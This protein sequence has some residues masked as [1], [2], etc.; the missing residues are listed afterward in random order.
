MRV[1]EEQFLVNWEQYRKRKGKRR[2]NQCVRFLLCQQ[3]LSIS[4]WQKHSLEEGSSGGGSDYVTPCV[5]SFPLLMNSTTGAVDLRAARTLIAKTW[6]H[7]G[8]SSEPVLGSFRELGL[9][10]GHYCKHLLTWLTNDQSQLFRVPVI[11]G[12]DSNG[13]SCFFWS[14]C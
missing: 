14:M 5:A 2:V 12:K 9:S 3:C 13:M 1:T 4:Q 8:L 6:Q 7:S 10:S 11:M